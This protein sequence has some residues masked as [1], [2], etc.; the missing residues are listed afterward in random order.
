[1]KIEPKSNFEPQH[2]RVE[3]KAL[4]K[5][6]LMRFKFVENYCKSHKGCKKH[7]ICE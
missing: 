6:T 3:E 1:M 7:T 4:D 2:I 5:A